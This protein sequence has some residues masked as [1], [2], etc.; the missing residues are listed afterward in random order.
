LSSK[1]T[2]TYVFLRTSILNLQ[3]VKALDLLCQRYGQRT[4]TRKLKKGI[5]LVV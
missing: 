4:V 1:T 5:I 2:E 3:Y